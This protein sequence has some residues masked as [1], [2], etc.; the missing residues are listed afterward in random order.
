MTIQVLH[1]R[2]DSGS[3]KI[4]GVQLD[5]SDSELET[6]A[7]VRRALAYQE[8]HRAKQM[9]FSFSVL[10]SP[11]LTWNKSLPTNS[12]RPDRLPA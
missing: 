7:R 11:L 4:D 5:L 3:G 6:A 2:P 1:G 9:S 10:G 8:S 12:L